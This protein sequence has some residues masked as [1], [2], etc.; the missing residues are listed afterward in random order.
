M[1]DLGSDLDPL[2]GSA[3]LGVAGDHITDSLGGMHHDLAE[4]R[5]PFVLGYLLEGFGVTGGAAPAA[6]RFTEI[7]TRRR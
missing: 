3:T 5:N 7:G 6:G 4:I 1:H 2:L